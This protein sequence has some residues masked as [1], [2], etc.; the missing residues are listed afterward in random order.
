MTRPRGSVPPG[1]FVR[2][3][4]AA[5]AQGHIAMSACPRV[6]TSDEP[7]RDLGAAKIESEKCAWLAPDPHAKKKI[8]EDFDVESCLPNKRVAILHGQI[9]N[10]V[11]VFSITHA[12]RED[13]D[14]L[15]AP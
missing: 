14:S 4:A 8:G 3:D 10:A 13:S 5:L 9:T 2:V 12:D 1:S 7:K 6:L 11:T 15:P